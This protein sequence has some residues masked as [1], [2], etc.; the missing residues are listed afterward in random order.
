M[1]KPNKGNIVN[2]GSIRAKEIVLIGNEVRNQ[3]IIKENGKETII[4]GSF[5]GY[6]DK[7]QI[8]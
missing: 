8:I 1:F 5:S 2:L 7:I 3:A 4:T 6:D